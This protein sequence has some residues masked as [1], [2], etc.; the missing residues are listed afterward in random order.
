MNRQVVS[1]VFDSRAE[2]ERALS[3]LRAAGVR[4]SA[5]S[6]VAR[7]DETEGRDR[8]GDDDDDTRTGLGIGIGAG[9]L[10]GFASLLIPGVGPFIAGGALASTLGA[11]GAIGAGAAIGGAVG[12][13]AGAL[14]DHGVDEADARYY[15]ERI[16]RGG[17]FLS[18]DTAEAGVDE[19]LVRD[20]LYGAG[21]H[22]ASRSRAATV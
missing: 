14:K 17:T 22:S 8:D 21:G 6:V 13:L 16:N 5:I 11:A 9:A 19:A 3:E 2:A 18:V 7:H 20:I 10:L 12:G 4:E 1:A 15:E